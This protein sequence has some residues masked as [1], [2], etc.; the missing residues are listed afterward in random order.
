MPDVIVIGAGLAGLA[1]ARDLKRQGASVRVL[2]GRSRI[3]GRV[4]S[5]RLSAGIT[6]DL[7]AQFVGEAHTQ[8]RTLVEEAGLHRVALNASGDM[9]YAGIGRK[10]RRAPFNSPRAL[11]WVA[12]LDA[13]LARA[14][15]E[16]ALRRFPEQDAV[17]LDRMAASAF[18]RE[19]TLFAQAARF[20][21]GYLE[22]EICTSLDQ[23]SAFELLEQ[24]RSVDGLAGESASAAWFLTDGAEGLATSLASGLGDALVLNASVTSIA[25]DEREVSIST[26]D[27]T[28]RASHAIITVP[29]QLYG[30]IGLLN[31]LPT[32]WQD[33]LT[34]W[35]LGS[36]VKT[37]LV[38]DRPW[39]R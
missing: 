17:E 10:V 1:A 8:V 31:A 28:H 30:S 37:I 20:V 36:V 32:A 11:G 34:T 35:R 5:Q 39:W 24:G 12:S 4:C 25:Q 19:H 2:E 27:R 21:G 6:I 26:P 33:V 23:V 14:R 18:L 15:L 3:G 16:R 38:F 29:P 7:G 22:G 9:L 13:W